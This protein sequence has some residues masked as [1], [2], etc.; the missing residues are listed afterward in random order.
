MGLFL[1]SESNSKEDLV[2]HIKD[3]LDLWSGNEMSTHILE[4]A[5]DSLDKLKKY[6]KQKDDENTARNEAYFAK[7]KTYPLCQYC[8]HYRRRETAE[9][10]WDNDIHPSYCVEVDF[11]EYNLQA[12]RNF[13]DYDEHGPCVHFIRKTE[14]D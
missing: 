11:N 6:S 9:I 3:S 1:F 7:K 5:Q 8:I 2:K 10:D 13:K 14:E 4:F 12:F